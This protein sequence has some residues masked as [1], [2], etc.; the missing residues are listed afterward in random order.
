MPNQIRHDLTETDPAGNIIAVT[1]ELPDGQLVRTA[2]PSIT[3]QGNAPSMGGAMPPPAP[4][5]IMPAPAAPQMGGLPPPPEA[6]APMAVVPPM[7][8]PIEGPRSVLDP[9]AQ[10][11]I[12]P[13]P[14]P[15]IPLAHPLSGEQGGAPVPV[16]APQIP[17]SATGNGSG[18]VDLASSKTTS[19]SYDPK[20]QKELDS[21]HS[22]VQDSVRSLAEA[23]TAKNDVAVQRAGAES[24][25]LND[26]M[27]KENARRAI[28]ADKVAMKEKDYQAEVDKMAG[29]KLTNPHMFYNQ[30]TSNQILAGIAVSLGALGQ[31]LGQPGTKNAG[32]ETIQATLDKDIAQQKYNIENQKDIANAK[33]TMYQDL[34]KKYGDERA[35]RAAY[36]EM[37]MN[38]VGKEFESRALATNNPIIKAKA[39]QSAADANERAAQAKLERSKVLFER[40]IDQKQSTAAPGTNKGP[41][42]YLDQHD[43][44]AVQ[45]RYEY[46]DGMRNLKTLF[47]D[48]KYKDVIGK[49]DS[50]WQGAK[51]A[52]GLEQDPRFVELKTKAQSMTQAL[53]KSLSGAGYSDSERQEYVEQTAQIGDNPKTALGKIDAQLSRAEKDNAKLHAGIAANYGND[54]RVLDVLK[55]YAAP[56]SSAPRGTP[57][58][59]GK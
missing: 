11:V 57:M 58:T 45:N 3:S 53:R 29:M 6:A 16:A 32:I 15:Q 33:R 10:S 59:R 30:S 17:L 40:S 54:P 56:S 36:Q 18:V 43:A 9:M 2:D 52:V 21:T 28:E 13:D 24:A 22:A 42:K 27:A 26:F 35:A 25:A 46:L 51:G 14:T 5:S 55:T 34:V 38:Q 8:V 31:A 1:V 7:D 49:L 20:L 4:E 39:E 12:N 48:P 47:A 37:V 41:V 44:E 50:K 19:A 23:E